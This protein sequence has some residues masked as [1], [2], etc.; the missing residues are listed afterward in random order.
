MV[1]ILSSNLYMKLIPRS[2]AGLHKILLTSVMG[3]PQ[4]FFDKTD[5]G[6]ILN[7]FSQDM[8]LID[9][10]LPG[11]AAMCFSAF[12]QC[13]A[14]FGLIAT[15][16]TYMA[17]ACPALVLCVYFLQ[18]FYLRT[19]RQMRFLDLECKSPLYTHFTETI[20]GLS[21][22]RAFG[23]EEHFLR[24]NVELLDKSQ[25]PHYLMYCIQRWFNLVLLL[26][27]GLTAVI[28]VALATNLTSTTTGGRLGVSLSSIVNFNFSL[29][30]FM[31]FWTQMETSLGAIA[32]LKSFE[33]E[34]VSEHKEEETFMPSHD[35]PT[36]GAIEF[37]NVSASHGYVNLQLV[38]STNLLIFHLARL[39]HF[40]TYP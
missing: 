37:R 40:A 17:L 5:S 19:S 34:T 4:S 2:G 18:S 33:K 16:S 27:V 29:G 13:L 26:L 25:R 35:W 1:L 36:S 20:E 10:S 24:E 7:R 11:A 12:L 6:L 22:I 9:A 3:A 28:V 15:G 39:P 32:R 21:T 31:M 23:W 14:Q 38:Q 8:T 30:M